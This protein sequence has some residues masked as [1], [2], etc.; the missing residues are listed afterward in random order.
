MHLTSLDFLLYREFTQ[1][2]W[3]RNR[4][5]S[6]QD[7]DALLKK[8]AGRGMPDFISWFK[9]QSRNDASMSPELRQIAN[10]C[11]YRVMSYNAYDVNGYRFHTKRYDE[12]RPNRRT[13]NFQVCT[14]ADDGVEY[15]GIIEEIYELSFI[16]RKPLKPVVFKCQSDDPINPDWDDYF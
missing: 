8:G 14:K 7:V 4:A 16:G 10:G 11:E 13:T 9:Q 2:F 15:Y 12:S 1:Q 5:P 6:P 3:Q